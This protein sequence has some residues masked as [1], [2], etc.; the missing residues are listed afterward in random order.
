MNL[1][2][3]VNPGR[4]RVG[5]REL[6]PRARSS[7]LRT[8]AF[9]AFTSDAAPSIALLRREPAEREFLLQIFTRSA[10][11]VL[12]NSRCASVQEPVLQVRIRTAAP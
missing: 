3:H 10:R 8:S 6:G 11:G 9:S 4:I 5:D 12:L 2:P 1:R 7:R